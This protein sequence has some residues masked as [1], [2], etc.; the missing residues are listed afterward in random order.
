[1][2]VRLLD[3]TWMRVLVVHVMDVAVLVRDGLVRVP[4]SVALGE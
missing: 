3:A 4:V 2:A 1:M